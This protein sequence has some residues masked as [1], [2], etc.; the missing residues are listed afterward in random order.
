MRKYWQLLLLLQKFYSDA[1]VS[2]SSMCFSY[3]HWW[4]APHTSWP[5]S[6][7]TLVWYKPYSWY[8]C[9][10]SMKRNN[11]ILSTPPHQ[12]LDRF[13][14]KVPLRRNPISIRQLVQSEKIWWWYSSNCLSSARICTL[15]VKNTQFGS[16]AKYTLQQS[17]IFDRWLLVLILLWIPFILNNYYNFKIWLV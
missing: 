4:Q 15:C 12:W 10:Y 11:G 5:T 8:K 7:Y 13:H 2:A 17:S 1:D 9:N 6:V 14:S 16:K 3:L